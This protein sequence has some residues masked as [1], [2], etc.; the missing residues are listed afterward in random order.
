MPTGKTVTKLNLF[1]STNA[2]DKQTE[3]NN[4]GRKTLI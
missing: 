4:S 2:N 3:D 1:P